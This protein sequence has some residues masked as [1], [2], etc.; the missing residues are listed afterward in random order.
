MCPD[1]SVTHVPGLDTTT[2]TSRFSGTHL[3]SLK[4]LRLFVVNPDG[5]GRKRSRAP[6]R[7]KEALPRASDAVR[8]QQTD[9]EQNDEN[10][11]LDPSLS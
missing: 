8:N 9:S 1:T 4:P 11:Y 3:R 6:H 10:V 2:H 7:R 5:P